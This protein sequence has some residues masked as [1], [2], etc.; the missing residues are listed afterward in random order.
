MTEYSTTTKRRQP[1]FYKNTNKDFHCNRLISDAGLDLSGSKITNLGN[2]TNPQDAATK[3]YVDNTATTINNSI[4][5]IN[6]TI[7]NNVVLQP[8]TTTLSF[9]LS[10]TTTSLTDV[11]MSLMSFTLTPGTWQL[12]FDGQLGISTSANSVTVGIF[13]AGILINGSSRSVYFTSASQTLA[14]ASSAEFFIPSNSVNIV[15]DVRWRTS[16]G[17]ATVTNRTFQILKIKN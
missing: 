10:S 12:R 13:T 14:V 5:T 4:T 7:T 2:P 15:V 3:N 11:P 6:N 9:S 1:A 8:A 16:A 17:T